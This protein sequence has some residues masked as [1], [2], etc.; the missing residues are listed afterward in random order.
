MPESPTA[1]VLIIG[2]N[3]DV[4]ARIAVFLIGAGYGVHVAATVHEGIQQLAVP[5]ALIVFACNV[6]DA[7]A[8][9]RLGMLKADPLPGER[10][11]II[12]APIGNNLDESARAKADTV[13][14]ANFT[15]TELIATVRSLLEER[16]AQESAQQVAFVRELLRE[17]TNNRFN[18]CGEP[19]DLPGELPQTGERLAL[20]SASLCRLRELVL[21]AA[22]RARF[23]AERAQDIVTATSEAAMNAVVHA[24]GGA[25]TVRTDGEDTVQVWI[26]D[27]G[28]GIP[29]ENL[30]KAALSR[31]YTTA[32]TL[33]HGLKLMLQTAD[34]VW[35]YTGTAGTTFVLEQKRTTP[36]A[37]LLPSPVN[38]WSDVISES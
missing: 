37:T 5:P 27:R 16:E 18:L 8:Y 14:P 20:T 22:I 38:A 1:R 36:A 9:R 17:A 7:A 13:L 28:K 15:V 29:I 19:A 26:K 2:D 11:V 4:R 25:A 33:G 6:S 32:A 10:T 34:V 23:T 30:P 3:D 35:L 31:G 21:V 24:S 12:V